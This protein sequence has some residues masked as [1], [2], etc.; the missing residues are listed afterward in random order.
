MPYL[1]N[2]NSILEALDEHPEKVR[3]LWIEAG[4]ER[5]SDE[6][7][8]AARERGLSFRILPREA[9]E[10][11]FRGIKSHIALER[12]EVAFIDPDVFLKELATEKTGVLCAFDGIYDPQNLG[13]ILRSAACF[14]VAAVIIPKDKS[15]GITETVMS[16]AKGGIEHV[17]IIRVVNLSRY[18]EELKKKG[19]FCYGLDEKAAKPLWDVDLK[20]L[21]CL[22]FGS[23]EGLR[24]LTMTTCDEIVKIPTE[25]L[26]PSLNVATSFA[27]SVYEAVRQVKGER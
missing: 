10:R 4:Y 3:R 13:N 16:V 19:V 22:V 20:G 9:F 17:K 1:T 6:V 18:L 26:F 27:V 21:V 23:E 14:G 11:R 12:D 5:A 8:R 25:P 15:C 2:K 7:I 24:R